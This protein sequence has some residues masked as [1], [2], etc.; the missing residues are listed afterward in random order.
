M[1]EFM[2]NF[3]ECVCGGMLDNLTYYQ[4]VTIRRFYDEYCLDKA[5]VREAIIKVTATGKGHH[6]DVIV[7]TEI[8][9]DLLKELG[10]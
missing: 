5:K 10:L 2:K 3:E 7:A 9:E 6:W 4:F 1:N 8:E